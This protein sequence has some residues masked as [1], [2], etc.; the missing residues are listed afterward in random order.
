[1]LKTKMFVRARNCETWYDE[2]DPARPYSFSISIDG[3]SNNYSWPVYE[4]DMQD[5]GDMVAHLSNDH[6]HDCRIENLEDVL[7]KAKATAY[8]TIQRMEEELMKLRALPA[9]SQEIDPLDE[10]MAGTTPD[11]IPF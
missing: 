3:D 4:F 10:L 2:Y 1:M 6:M 8:A 7:T 11:D 9:P 5:P